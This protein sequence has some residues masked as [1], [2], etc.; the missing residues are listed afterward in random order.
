MA[1]VEKRGQRSP[2]W[3]V[4]WRELG[5]RESEK[6]PTPE[7]AEA[8]RRLIESNGD[9]RVD[10]LLAEAADPDRPVAGRPCSFERW[11]AF[12]MD[13]Y[14]GPRETTLAK[15]RRVVERDLIPAFGS[16]DITAITKQHDGAWVKQ[17]QAAGASPKTIRNKHA[18]LF[19]IMQA[20][21]DF[22]P[23]P[24]RTRNPITAKLPEVLHEEQRFLTR[25][26]QFRGSTGSGS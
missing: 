20:A 23:V 5:V 9:C 24:M 15:Y 13:T 17:Q 21:V 10:L 18:L 8:Y 2:Y 4:V 16:L 12:W 25:G 19:Q 11:A 26:S 3:R 14:T 22:D 6:F 7:Q 1:W